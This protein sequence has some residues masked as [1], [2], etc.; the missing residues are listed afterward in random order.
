MSSSA[1]NHRLNRVTGDLAEILM[2]LPLHV[3]GSSGKSTATHL[4]Y[5]VLKDG[6]KH[7]P[8]AYVLSGKEVT[9]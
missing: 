5:E 4:H 9:D 6:R 3:V 1:H 8:L 7:N 2:S